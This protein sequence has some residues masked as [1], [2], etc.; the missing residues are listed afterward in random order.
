MMVA[1]MPPKSPDIQPVMGMPLL[2]LESISGCH[3]RKTVATPIMFEQD[4]PSIELT[5]SLQENLTI[6]RECNGQDMVTFT[7]AGSTY[8]A[9]AQDHLK[10]LNRS[11]S[12]REVVKLTLE[13]EPSNPVDKNAILVNFDGNPIGY[14]PSAWIGAM[15]KAIKDDTIKSLSV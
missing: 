2:K 9:G 15:H 1:A 5:K 12:R 14:I 3:C 8:I 11:I 7:L 6:G 10:K 13:P 4:T